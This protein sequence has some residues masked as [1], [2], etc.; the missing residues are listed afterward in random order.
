AGFVTAGALA[1]SL[2][3]VVSAGSATGLTLCPVGEI[4]KNG[5]CVKKTV[6]PVVPKPPQTSG[7]GSGGTATVPLPKPPKVPLPTGGSSGGSSSGGSSSGG[8]SSS[9]GGAQLPNL[10]SGTLPGGA[11]TGDGTGSVSGG[12]LSGPSVPG[13]GTTTAT[14][15]G[16]TVPGAIPANP[17]ATGG[18]GMLSPAA[19]YLPSAG[20]LGFSNFSGTGFASIPTLSS[21]SAV[22][23]PLLASEVP[24]PLLA[25]QPA[26][27]LVAVQ[28]PLLAAGEDAGSGTTSTVLTSFGGYALPGLLVVLATAVVGVVGAGNV[29]VWQTRFAA[30]RA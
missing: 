28:A 10:P 14:T 18:G 7:S 27:Q 20:I 23:S 29:R 6:T 21:L 24:S 15:D 3:G 5:A 19:A 11:T 13:T 12:G 26:A 8:A 9:S 2:S 30:R 1:L 4:L 25:S 17:A 22:P 16:S